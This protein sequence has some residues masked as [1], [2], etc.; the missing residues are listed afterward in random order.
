MR[1]FMF[2]LLLAINALTA[3]SQWSNNASVNNVVS[4]KV[5]SDYNPIS[6]SDNAN[7]AI[8]FFEDYFDGNIYAQHM[9]T[10]GTI[11]WGS[12]SNPVS[13]CVSA[14]QK[15]DA[16]AI[17]DGSGGAF[18]AW[19]D[20]RHDAYIGEVYIQKI[21][22]AGIAQWTANG[23]RVTNNVSRDD[24]LPLLCQDGLG[25]VILTWYGDDTLAHTIQNYAQRYNSA[26]AAQWVADGIQV[27]TA[28]GFRASSSI[29]PDG[30][31]GAFIF[32]IDTRNDPNGMD[33][34]YLSNND[35]T[36]SDIYG[37]RLDG[38]GARLWTNNGAAIITA[39][40]NQNDDLEWDA[41]P[42]GSGNV[43]LVFNDGRNDIGSYTNYDIYAQ[44]VNSNGVPQ[45]AANGIAVCTAAEN[46][47]TIGRASDGAGGVVVSINYESLNRIYAQK[48]TSAGA[49]A[50]TLNGVPVS[51]AGQVI[52]DGVMASDGSG[53]SI[54]CFSTSVNPVLKAQKLNS[55]GILQ[56][57][58]AGTDVC[59]N[60]LST[61]NNP[62]IILSD[63]GSFII[64]WSDNRNS[65]LPS[66]QDIY[67][68]KV[69]ATGVLAGTGS[70]PYTT[71]A[72]GNWNN[73][74]IWS[75]GIV[76]PVAAVVIIRHNVIGNV[77]A[78]CASVTV[79]APGNLT[80]NNGILFS[81]TN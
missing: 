55:A 23:V 35:L 30:A 7:G 47:F 67:A 81:V 28:A 66:D 6:V 78:S 48:I 9:T 21:S 61:P 77:N 73:P 39:P 34:S 22:S 11:A 1:K 16:S 79:E 80:V 26:G 27:T 54:F 51:Q 4:N 59:N 44:K 12:S 43:I 10:A 33:Y 38:A 5:G 63:V 17:A 57:G 72:N 49:A 46:Q 70:S 15:Y 3:K 60:T 52:Y 25:G 29:L 74:V 42:D 64:S 40:G 71:V 75:G 69:L 41:L 76:P 56:W 53:N 36:N 65:A 32:F 50:W 13:V 19:T 18:V 14:G 62:S 8:I 68:S 20:Y 2:L 58:I 24:L 37:Q 31:N 45:W